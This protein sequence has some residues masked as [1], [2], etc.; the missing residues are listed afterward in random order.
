MQSTVP[1]ALSVRCAKTEAQ[2]W[3]VLAHAPGQRG[4]GPRHALFAQPS[5]ARNLNAGAEPHCLHG[6]LPCGA[7]CAPAPSHGFST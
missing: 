7:A 2:Y 4:H 3:L 1:G 6:M 5:W